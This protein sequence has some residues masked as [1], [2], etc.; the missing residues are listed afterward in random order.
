MQ[1]K[2]NY[3]Q[4]GR[5]ESEGGPTIKHCAQA[6]Q[7]WV[8]KFHTIKHRAQ[9]LQEWVNKFHTRTWHTSKHW[10]QC[11]TGGKAKANME[12]VNKWP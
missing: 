12:W 8:N 9:A 11:K 5:L 4:T 10:G 1:N 3:D 7:E 6:L 2:W